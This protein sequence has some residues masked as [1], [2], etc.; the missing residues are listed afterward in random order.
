[1]QKCVVL[2]TLQFNCNISFSPN[3]LVW[4]FAEMEEADIEDIKVEKRTIIHFFVRQGK[5]VKQTSDELQSA[6]TVDEVL[7][8]KT[9]YR[10]HKAF[11]DGR[12]SLS[13]Q[14]K[15]GQLASQ[16]T[17]VNVNTMSCYVPL[18]E[19]KNYLSIF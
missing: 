10:W 5:M 13:S 16:I 17:E 4:N 2:L 14:P 9:V 1:M 15:N 12:K 11:W 6:Y 7:P 3:F 18:R 8:E 19:C